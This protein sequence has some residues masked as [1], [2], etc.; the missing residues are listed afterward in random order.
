MA[1]SGKVYGEKKPKTLWE[2]ICEDFAA[3]RAE[4]EDQDFDDTASSAPTDITQFSASRH[5]PV[6]YG[7]MVHVAQVDSDLTQDFDPAMSHPAAIGLSLLSR[8]NKKPA[9]PSP[10]PPD[11]KL[12]PARDYLEAYVFPTLIPAMIAMLQQAKAERCFERK[13][14]KFNACDFLTEYLYK[15]NPEKKI[16]RENMNLLDISFVKEHLVDHPRPPLPLSLLWSEPE[17]AVKIQSFWRGHLV[18]IR[19]EVQEMRQWQNEWRN[20]NKD[21][22]QQVNEFWHQQENKDI[23]PSSPQQIPNVSKSPRTPERKSRKSS[24][25]SGRRSKSNLNV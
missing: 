22:R 7:K 5:T 19:P 15:Q 11:P 10:A 1:S 23:P 13:R 4:F 18:R 21:V 2:K 8:P 20:E 9:H 24:A 16:G 3:Q 17:A 14:T 25:S 6:V 12:C